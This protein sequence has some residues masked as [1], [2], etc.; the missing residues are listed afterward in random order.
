MRHTAVR[1]LWL[2][3]EVRLGRVVVKKALGAENPADLMTKFLKKS[4]VVDR[5]RRMGIDW[6]DVGG[7][8]TICWAEYRGQPASSFIGG[9]RHTNNINSRRR[10]LTRSCTG[11]GGNI[12]NINGRR[13]KAC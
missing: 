11:G 10:Q 4:D 7:H 1:E 3:E 6:N 8:P 2:Q 5:L 9:G 13:R 12:D